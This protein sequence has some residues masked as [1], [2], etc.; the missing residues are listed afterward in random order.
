MMAVVMF[1][2]MV[3]VVDMLFCFIVRIDIWQALPLM[4]VILNKKQ[5]IPHKMTCSP[6]K[7]GQL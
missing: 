4:S 2:V 3:S 6:S 5:G 7:S 1:V